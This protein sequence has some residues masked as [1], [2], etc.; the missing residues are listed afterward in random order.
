MRRPKGIDAIE[1][2]VRTD[3]MPIEA[4]LCRSLRH[5]WEPVTLGARRR[6]ALVKDGVI[7]GVRACDRCGARRIVVRDL[8][9]WN[10]ISTRMEYPDG[11]LIGTRGSGRLPMDDASQALFVRSGYTVV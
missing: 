6:A 3:D 9:N 5:K 11:Y 7:E 2:D 4:L 10:I 1:V 8:A